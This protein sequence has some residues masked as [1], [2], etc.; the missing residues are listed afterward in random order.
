MLAAV[1]ADRHLPAVTREPS[2]LVRRGPDMTTSRRLA[3]TTDVISNAVWIGMGVLMGAVDGKTLILSGD[4]IATGT[5]Q[6]PA[7]LSCIFFFLFEVNERLE[8]VL[9]PDI[10][11]L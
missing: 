2:V 8:L 6:K 9:P 1:T 3:E 11:E 10:E 4:C 7:P 5:T